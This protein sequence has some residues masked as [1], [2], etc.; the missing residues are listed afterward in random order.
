[1]PRCKRQQNPKIPKSGRDGEWVYYLRGRTPCRRRYVVPRDP[2]TSK[3]L[4]VR[5][6][7]GAASK[8]WSYSQALTVEGL[9]GVWGC[10]TWTEDWRSG[11]RGG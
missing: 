1:M 8:E 11:W 5:A 6:K 10:G 7:L 3:Q 9:M 4:Q 2:R